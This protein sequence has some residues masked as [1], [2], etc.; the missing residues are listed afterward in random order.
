MKTMLLI[1]VT[2]VMALAGQCKQVYSDRNL[3]F[4]CEDGTSILMVAPRDANGAREIYLLRIVKWKG[5]SPTMTIYQENYPNDEC[6]EKYYYVNE[7]MDELNIL[8]DKKVVCTGKKEYKPLSAWNKLK[9]EYTFV[10][11]TPE[12]IEE[13]EK[14]RMSKI[15]SSSSSSSDDANYSDDELEEEELY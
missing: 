13:K 2:A 6:K 11:L 5:E 1:L 9:K 4:R 7:V 12:E 15:Y 3:Q 14:E 10:Y 8:Q